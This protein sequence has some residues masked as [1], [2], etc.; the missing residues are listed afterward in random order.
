MYKGRGQWQLG[1]LT[2][3]INS[4]ATGYLPLPEFPREAPDPSVRDVE[5]DV[6]GRPSSGKDKKK[7]KGFYDD[8]ESDES[9]SSSGSD[10]YSSISG[11]DDSGSEGSESDTEGECVCVCSFL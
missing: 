2:H 1:S 10:F 8:E 6:W 3:A 9:E 7:E 4:E 11:S 5:E